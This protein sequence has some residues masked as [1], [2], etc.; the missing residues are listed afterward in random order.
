VNMPDHQ[1]QPRCKA[2]LA[3]LELLI[4]VGQA[5]HR[6]RGRGVLWVTLPSRSIYARLQRE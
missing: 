5:G 1:Q 2:A 6:R 3:G 4:H